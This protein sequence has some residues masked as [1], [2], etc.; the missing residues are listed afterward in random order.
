MIVRA[1]GLYW[2]ITGVD[3]D[4]K[5]VFGVEKEDDPASQTWNLWKQSGIYC[6]YNEYQPI[7]VGR[8]LVDNL[9][10]RLDSHRSDRLAGRWDSFSWFG[11]RRLNANGTMQNFEQRMMTKEEI[12]KSLEAFALMAFDP[13]LNRRHET[14]PGAKQLIQKADKPKAIRTLVE[15]IHKKVVNPQPAAHLPAPAAP[16]VP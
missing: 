6:L 11:A 9:G 4:R 3:W 1:F 10:D 14:I 15:E 13:R 16:A 7:Y 5:K 8:A 2:S 12:V